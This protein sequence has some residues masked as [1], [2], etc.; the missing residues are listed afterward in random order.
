MVQAEAPSIF[1]PDLRKRRLERAAGKFFEHAF[2]H[3]RV[4]DDIV[5][6]L[7]TVMRRFPEALFYGPGGPLLE[8]RLTEKAGVGDVIMAGES[9]A[10]LKAQ[11]ASGAVETRA[12]ALPLADQSLDLVVSTMSLH[13][14]NDLPGALREARRVLRPDGLFIG[15]F[16]A[17]RTLSGLRGALRDAETALTGGLSPRVSPFVAIKDAGGLLQGAGFALPVAD[18]F[19]LRVRYRNPIKLFEDLRGMGE[20]AALAKGAKTALRRD[21]LA[22]VLARLEGQDTLFEILVVTGWAPHPGQQKP[23][24]PGSAKASLADAVLK[25]L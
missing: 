12:T 17:E 10:F 2:L 24:K 14:E 25:G 11:G 7:E 18:S 4:A 23:L 6:R 8:R 9:G 22:S 19:P 15:A 5:D 20:T 3:E 16:P 1:R 21:V 13:A